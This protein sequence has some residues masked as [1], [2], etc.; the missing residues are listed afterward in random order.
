MYKQYMWRQNICEEVKYMVLPEQ[1]IFLVN[2]ID[3]DE[4][5]VL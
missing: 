2:F 1:V 3:L 5:F 4:N